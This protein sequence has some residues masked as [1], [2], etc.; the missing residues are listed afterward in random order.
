MILSLESYNRSFLIWKVLL[1]ILEIYQ[2]MNNFYRHDANSILRF[3]T[4]ILKPI[5][6]FVYRVINTILAN[7]LFYCLLT[8]T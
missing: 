6:S 1:R 4:F 2:G 5:I 8:Y 7:H 3:Y